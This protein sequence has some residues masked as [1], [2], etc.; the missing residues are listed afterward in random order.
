MAKETELADAIERAFTSPNVSDSNGESANL[1]DV[2]DDRLKWL[3]N[4]I[5]PRSAVPSAD[6][7]GTGVASLAEAV[8]GVTAGLCR[9]AD[10]IEELAGAVRDHAI[11]TRKA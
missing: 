9:I 1:V 6:A 3:G 2:L 5:I 10:A 4:A 7:S 11:G 8:M